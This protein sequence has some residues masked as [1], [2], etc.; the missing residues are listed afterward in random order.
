VNVTGTYEIATIADVQKDHPALG[1]A[2]LEKLALGKG[3]RVA[4][5]PDTPVKSIANSD[6]GPVV[7]EIQDASTH[8]IV[9]T[10]DPFSTNW[11]LDSG[12]VLFLADA[13]SYLGDVNAGATGGLLQTG[14][15]MQTRLPTGAA[16]VRLALPDR[17]SANLEPGVDGSVAFGP[18]YQV[19]LY[20]L[21]WTGPATAIDM[22]SGGRVRRALAA[23][24]IDTAES[25]TTAAPTLSLASKV[26]AAEGDQDT[27]LTRKLWPWLVLAALAIV[28]LE[29]FVYN[30]K[31]SI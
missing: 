24:L 1:L 3:T 28:M 5:A 25:D 20:T 22:E 21:S 29:W 23:N 12:W 18:L 4:I 9:V 30:R 17:E 31:V 7:L 6:K 8:A 14:T 13:L 27:R 26:V 15:V 19:G 2:G 16:D 10:F 11:P